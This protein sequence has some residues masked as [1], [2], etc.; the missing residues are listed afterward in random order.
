MKPSAA[1]KVV[2]LAGN[3]NTGKSTVF[4]AL[5]GG[6][7][8]TGNWPGKT[9]DV[10]YGTLTIQSHAYTIVDLPGT[11]S[12]MT[13]SEEERV[14]RDFL[15]TEAPDATV[16]VADATCLERN[17]NLVLQVAEITNRV[18]LCVNLI[19]EARRH[20]ITVDGG[21]LGHELG[22]PVVLTAARSGLGLAE[23]KEAIA[24]VVQGGIVP[25]PRLV[26]YPKEIEELLRHVAEARWQAVQILCTDSASCADHATVRGRRP[27]ET[28]SKRSGSSRRH[29]F[30]DI[31]SSTADR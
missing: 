7:Q 15:C 12:L 3:P 25:A 2:A 13:N 24:G 18:I 31:F 19:D 28:A 8:H 1:R 30:S 4:N 14:A 11:Y 16:V 29:R 22:L 27:Y 6:R 17:L 9:V 10:A 5:T 21:I 26:E 23:L 20:G